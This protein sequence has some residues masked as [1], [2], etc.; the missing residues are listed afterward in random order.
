TLSQDEMAEVSY[1]QAL[2]HPTWNMGPKVT[3]DSASLMNKALELVEA[4]W[5]FDTVSERIDVLIHPQSIVHSMIEFI[6]GGMLAQLGCPDMR[7]PIQVAFMYP[8]RRSTGLPHCDL[9]AEAPLEFEEPDRSRFPSLDIAR[10]ALKKGGTMPSVMNAANEVAVEAF[11]RGAISF[12]AIWEVISET[13]SRHTPLPQ[14]RLEDI[15]DSDRW[16][17]VAAGEAVDKHAR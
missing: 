7:L 5:L 10:F 12:P 9:F 1:Q 13:M 6:D 8:E 11:A 2:A 16:A 3:I 4:R 17:R 15:L 14:D